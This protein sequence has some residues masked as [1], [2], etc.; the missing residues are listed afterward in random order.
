MKWT[1]DIKKNL[2]IY[3]KIMS[4][5]KSEKYSKDFGKKEKV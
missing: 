1:I 3:L 5:K 4:T 2:L